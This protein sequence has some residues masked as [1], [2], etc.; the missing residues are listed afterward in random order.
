MT[1]MNDRI[2]KIAEQAGF[3]MWADEP[4]GRGQ[5]IDWAVNYDAEL[6]KFAELIMQECIEVVNS[7][8]MGDL[9][10][11]DQEVRRCVED[12]KQHFGVE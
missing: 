11:E 5:V 9:N 8:Y 10:R 3:I 4:W 12:L 6:E 2:K 7:R 1:Q